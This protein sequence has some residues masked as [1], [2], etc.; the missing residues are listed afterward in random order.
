[1]TMQITKQNKKGGPY[2]K[3][4]QEKRRNQVYE[5]YFEKGYT[6]VNMAAEL[7][8]NRNTINDDIKYW[9]SQI[10][11][12][13]GK[14]FLGG[15]FLKQIER[16]EIQRKRLLDEL[17]KQ[18]DFEARFKLEKLLFDLEQRVTTFVS[19]MDPKKIPKDDVPTQEI[20]EDEISKIVRFIVFDFGINPQNVSD[21]EILQGIIS[22]KKCK[23]SDA[24]KF[25]AAMKD[26]G[27]RLYEV[28]Q[29]TD[30]YNLISFGVSRGFIKQKEK[31]ELLKKLKE[32]DKIEEQR[33]DEIQKKYEKMYGSDQSKWSLEIRE[34]MDDEILKG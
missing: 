19:K 9:Y 26:L 25:I 8:V 14:D 24:E 22:L 18:T 13:S 4:Q 33:L 6:A 32:D 2:T 34:K 28:E 21:D 20:S 31:D 1:M 16:F 5:M 7:D 27:I 10:G 15:I 30:C 29:Y 3:T 11:S 12:Q 17:E 23:I